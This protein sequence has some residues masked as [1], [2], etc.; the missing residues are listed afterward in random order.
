[1]TPKR[2][3]I[4]T[5]LIILI[6]GFLTGCDLVTQETGTT[7]TTEAGRKP[8]I[9]KQNIEEAQKII[10]DVSMKF[11]S[12][13]E[14]NQVTVEITLDNPNGKPVTSVE[15][16]LSYDPDALS[17]QKIETADS[18]FTAPYDNNFDE[19]NGLVMI[20]R[21]NN[22]PLTAKT[23]NVAEVIFEIMAEGVTMIDAYDYQGNLLGHVSANMMSEDTPYNILLKPES[24]V[25]II[26]NSKLE[27]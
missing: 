17:G 23:I 7:A 13:Q 27:N 9:P 25:L 6:S 24:P 20:G 14:G 19:V 15:S 18:D 1:M 21:A 16:W 4:A 5:A 26:Q 8:S 22:Q 10:K 2:I 3:L 11:A 12:K